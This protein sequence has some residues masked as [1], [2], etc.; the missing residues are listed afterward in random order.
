MVKGIKPVPVSILKKY[1]TTLRKI[2]KYVP[3][4]SDTTKRDQNEGLHS[5]R[6]VI[7]ANESKGRVGERVNYLCIWLA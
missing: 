4:T 3:F 5:T 1:I 2:Q 6:L 7:Y